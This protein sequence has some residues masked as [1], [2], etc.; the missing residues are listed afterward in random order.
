MLKQQL[1]EAAAAARAR[2]SLGLLTTADLRGY[3][4]KV[5]RQAAKAVDLPYML[6]RGESIACSV[7][8]SNASSLI[9]KLALTRT[10]QATASLQATLQGHLFKG[11]SHEISCCH[12]YSC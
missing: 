10:L 7:Y 5:Q 8:A 1:L 9:I 11:C 6:V 3:S 4:N 12:E 2:S